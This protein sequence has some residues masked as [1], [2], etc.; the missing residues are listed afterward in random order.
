MSAKSVKALPLSDHWSGNE[1]DETVFRDAR[2]ERRFGELLCRL[3]DRMGGTI[4]LACE[5]WASTVAG[6][7]RESVRR[8]PDLRNVAFDWPASREVISLED[9]GL[10]QAEEDAAKHMIER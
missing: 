3:S 2:L 4:P 8:H 9:L 1:V 5:D 10:G 6:R 7:L